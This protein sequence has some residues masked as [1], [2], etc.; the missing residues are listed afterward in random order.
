MRQAWEDDVATE[1]YYLVLAE[2]HGGRARAALE[3]L[4]QVERATADLLASVLARLGLLP[5]AE[6]VMVGR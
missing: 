2:Q 6:S 5:S 4:A 1:T 3:L